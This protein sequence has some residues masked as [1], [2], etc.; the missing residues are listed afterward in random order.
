MKKISYLLFTICM[1][2]VCTLTVSA[3]NEEFV[4]SETITLPIAETPNQYIVLVYD[5]SKDYDLY[6]QWVKITKSQYDTIKERLLDMG[7]A[8]AEYEDWEFEKPVST[9]YTSNGEYQIAMQSWDRTNYELRKAYE[10]SVEDYYGAYPNFDNSKWKAMNNDGKVELPSESYDGL[11]PYVLFVKFEDH[12][13]SLTKHAVNAYLVEKHITTPETPSGGESE[14]P[15]GEVPETPEVEEPEGPTG[16]IDDTNW[17]KLKEAIKSNEMIGMFNGEDANV[18]FDESD[19]SKLIITIISQGKTYKIVLN[20]DNPTTVLS[21]NI[22]K[23]SPAGYE[24]V[25][26][27]VI[28][29]VLEEYCGIFEYDSEAFTKWLEENEGKLTLEENGIT[30]V[31]KRFKYEETSD[32]SNSVLSGDYIESFSIALMEPIKGYANPTQN[33]PEKE[34]EKESN[35][36]TG[37]LSIMTIAGVLICVGG[38][39]VAYRKSRLN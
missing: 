31:M 39:Y 38:A 21:Y 23:T 29:S 19:S 1:L 2:L 34:D 13:N 9:D 33:V 27:W 37:D 6:S 22:D 25:N 4:L 32:I 26:S 12:E 17:K 16:M 7:T 8:R 35:P 24:F 14:Q 15:E 5:E 20:Y 10:Q 36:K 30:Y 11:Q 3:I 28:A 18:S